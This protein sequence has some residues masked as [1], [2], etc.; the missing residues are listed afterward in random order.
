MKRVENESSGGKENS[1]LNIRMLQQILSARSRCEQFFFIIA[2][3]VFLKK[4]SWKGD[5]PIQLC[6]NAWRIILRF[7]L[8]HITALRKIRRGIESTRDDSHDNEKS[9]SLIALYTHCSRYF[10]APNFLP[11]YYSLSLSL[12]LSLIIIANGSPVLFFFLYLC[13]S[14]WRI[15]MKTIPSSFRVSRAIIAITSH[16]QK[17]SLHDQGV[18]AVFFSFLRLFVSRRPLTARAEQ[19]KAR[20]VQAAPGNQGELSLPSRQITVARSAYNPAN[21]STIKGKTI[22]WR[23]GIQREERDPLEETSREKRYKIYATAKTAMLR[24]SRFK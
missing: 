11:S 14:S 21:K 7:P 1:L 18:S 22:D 19:T 13:L 10:L 9:T 17:I 8:V 23:W 2:F 12:L 5:A 3:V 24:R 15:I 20:A 6:V 16:C 4:F